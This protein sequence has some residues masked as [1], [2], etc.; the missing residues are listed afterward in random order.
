MGRPQ[1]PNMEILQLAVAQLGDLVNEMVFL[2]GC[3]T[4]LLITDPAAPSIRMTRDV[5]VIVQVTSL[6]EY[7]RLSEKLRTKGFK[8]DT[9]DDAPICRWL[10]ESVI[11]DVL[12]TNPEILG[13]G[14]RWYQ[15]AMEHSD[16]IK[17]PGGKVIRMVSAPYFL[18]TKLEAFE[19]RGMGDYLLSHD[20][21]DII[22]VLDG[23][24]ETMEEIKRADTRLAK[25]LSKRFSGL[26]QDNRFVD[27]VSGHMP[28][29]EASQA[30]A[31]FVLEIIKQ[32]TLL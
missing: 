1:N 24:P 32:I 15:A 25:T 12:P 13:F 23:R 8:E 19:G 29:D 7:S 28:S 26:I 18:I 11:L 17:L 2:G 27:S 14:N 9:S 5:D 30:R 21:E 3:A 22:A 31:A 10:A 20:M 4:G 16:K 6:L